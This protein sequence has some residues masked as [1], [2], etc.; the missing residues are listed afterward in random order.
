MPQA[1]TPETLPTGGKSRRA[2]ALRYLP[3]ALTAALLG[4]LFWLYDPRALVAA[5]ADIRFGPLAVAVL[6]TVLTL[7]VG[8]TD[9]WR[10][11]VRIGGIDLSFSE[12]LLMRLGGMPLKMVTPMRV[13]EVLRAPYLVRRH[14]ASLAT[15]VGVLAFEKAVIVLGVAPALALRVV[16]YGEWGSLLVLVATAVLVTALATE[17]GRATILAVVAPLG[18]KMRERTTHLL[19][20]FAAAG[21]I[22]VLKQIAYST[23]LMAGEAAALAFCLRAVGVDL[24]AVEWITI[25]PAVLLVATASVTIGGLGAREAA[26]VLLFPDLDPQRLMAGGLVFFAVA[27]VGLAVVGLPWV[28]AYLRRMVEDPGYSR[29]SAK[30]PISE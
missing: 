27:K 9:R 22:G 2:A 8:V 1:T 4:G 3:F 5:F 12:A 30:S 24:P 6:L 14:G 7:V 10:R 23:V 25:L 26:L 21:Y 15:A 17:D 11:I 29:R 13:S 18:A 19:G 20:A 16:Y 28:P